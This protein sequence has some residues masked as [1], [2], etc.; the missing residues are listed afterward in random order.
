MATA[1]RQLKEME[2]RVKGVPAL[3]REV[4]QLRAEKDMLLLQLQEKSAA[5]EVTKQQQQTQRRA[6]SST[7]TSEEPPNH[8]ETTG[9][10]ADKDKDAEAVE[11]R[12]VGV[13]EEKPMHLAV[14]YYSRGVKDAA[15]SAAVTV[16]EK[17]TETEARPGKEQETQAAAETEDVEVWVMEAMLGV[18]SEAQREMDTL[19]D[20]IKF[21]QESIQALEERLSEAG[22]QVE[23]FRAKAEESAARATREVGVLAAP[24]TAS[25]QTETRAAE[26]KEAEV[27]C[28]VEVRDA[29]VGGH[30]TQSEEGTQTEEQKTSVDVVSVGCQCDELQVTEQKNDKEQRAEKMEPEP[31]EPM[32]PRTGLLKSI[33]KRSDGNGSETR[34]TNKKSL[35]FVGILNG[36]YESTSSEDEEEE[37]RGGGGGRE[38]VGGQRGQRG[39]GERGRRGGRRELRGRGG[40][41]G[42]DVGG[43]EERE[44]G[45]ERHGRRG[46]ESD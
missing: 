13:G 34:S 41:G 2:E 28:G 12:S 18:T 32:T 39:G 8:E 43:G 23:N 37:G 36:G 26:V 20:T 11:R 24:E 9:R 5:L 25:V 42:G 31:E 30:L 14:F 21:Q 6:E 4:A 46:S 22:R 27:W 44:S 29:S 38:L 35:Q 15:V 10:R 3:E 1:L 19:Q 7:Q 45:R 16:N 17:G 40:A 33:M